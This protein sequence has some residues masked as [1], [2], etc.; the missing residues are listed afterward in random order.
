[1]RKLRSLLRDILAHATAIWR[2]V[3]AAV[4]RMSAC[5]LSSDELRTR[6]EIKNINSMRFLM[7]AI[8]YE[9]E[10]QVGLYDNGGDVDS[11]KPGYMILTVMTSVHA[12]KEEAHD[13]RYFPDP[14]LLPVDLR[15]NMW[16]RS[17]P[18]FRNCRMPN[19]VVSSWTIIW[20]ILSRTGSPCS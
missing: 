12:I 10:R 19:N 11:G 6:A 20:R 7:Q 3:V 8:E 5:G 16:T 2:R 14:D 15:K 13:Y 4:M 1:M 18:V 9:A 17:G